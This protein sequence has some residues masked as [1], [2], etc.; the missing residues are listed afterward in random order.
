MMS[1]TR[2]S[3]QQYTPEDWAVDPPKPV[4]PKTFFFACSG[5]GFPPSPLNIPP[6]PP[7]APPPVL[8]AVVVAAEPPNTDLQ[9]GQRPHNEAHI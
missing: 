1:S 3:D 7:N 6:P 2:A 5:V 9:N 8:L 4:L